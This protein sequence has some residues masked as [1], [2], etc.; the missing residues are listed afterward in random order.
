MLLPSPLS[1]AAAVSFCATS[2]SAVV[3]TVWPSGT[4][5]L[6]NVKDWL[7]GLGAR[8]L[9][10][11][12]VPLT[13]ET[14]ELLTVMALYDGEEWLES[15]CWYMEQP[16]PS[17]PPPAPYAGAKW[18]R[19]L[20]FKGSTREPHAIVLDVSAATASVWSSKYAIRAAL[21]RASGNPG[22]SCIHLT[23][24]Q[25]ETVLAERRDGERRRARGMGCDDS[26]AF[27]CAR[28]LLHPDSVAWLNSDATGLA[29]RE[30]GSPAFRAAWAQY[31]DWLH[32]PHA[33]DE[34]GGEASGFDAAPS[35]AAPAS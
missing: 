17:G 2:P 14:S 35:F 29:T 33:A 16:L 25:D 24:E 9:H 27:A 32:A 23:D 31:T 20:C 21:A 8:I 4:G 26:Y 1:A 11:S 10:A 19:A 12:P 7:D 5:H 15:N 30:L 22:N 13:T 3:L 28:A 34:G 18:K 6:A